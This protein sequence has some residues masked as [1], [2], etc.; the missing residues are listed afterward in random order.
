MKYL[1]VWGLM[2]AYVSTAW[3]MDMQ[4][5][6]KN[7]ETRFKL[8][9]AQVPEFTSDARRDEGFQ[10]SMQIASA[11]RESNSPKDALRKYVFAFHVKPDDPSALFMIGTVLIELKGYEE[12]IAIFEE[13][14][15]RKLAGAG[16]NNNL[17]WIYCTAEDP[18]FRD[19]RKAE[20]YAL[21]AL[22]SGEATAG[23]YHVWSTLAE[24][25]YIYG[26]YEGAFR[27]ATQAFMLAQAAT[28]NEAQLQ[29]Y[30]E[31]LEKCERA[32]GAEKEWADNAK[33]KK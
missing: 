3:S 23:D 7:V 24:A 16:V 21:K 12:A 9:V 15:A 2:L 6:I 26:N 14:D 4:W 18:K 10:R 17:G 11:Y 13:L 22:F 27:A 32:W 5:V 29:D 19:G 25:R 1:M 30:K 8:P 20:Q 31:L 28:N 33:V